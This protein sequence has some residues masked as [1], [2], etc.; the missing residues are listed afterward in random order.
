MNTDNDGSS[1]LPLKELTIE[2]L[3]HILNK[4][5]LY[6][7]ASIVKMY[8]IQN[9]QKLNALE[10]ELKLFEYSLGYA[11]MNCLISIDEALKRGFNSN[12]VASAMT[13]YVVNQEVNQTS[14]VK[15]LAI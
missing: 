9:I 6:K 11:I 5:K 7:M 1:I 4:I 14:K 3:N 8:N 12:Y 10:K 15:A 13:N 2:N